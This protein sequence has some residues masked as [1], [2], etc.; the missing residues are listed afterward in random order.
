MNG[1]GSVAGPMDYGSG[2]IRPKHALDPGLV[3][4]ASYQDYL[5]FACASAGSQL[6]R[7]FPCPA[8]PPP[9]YQ[10]NHPSVAVHGFNGSVT[11]HRTVTNVG[12]GE[13]RYTVAVV[14]PAGVSVKVSPKRLSFARAGEKKAFRITMEA[15]KGSS[16]GRVARGQFVA[17]S[18]A[19][20][21]GAHVV[22]SPIVVLVA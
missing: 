22:R 17:G 18:Y 7:S 20:S 8:R 1:D 14:E 9:P 11:V 12:S 16:S 13:A 2:H 15:K 6:D 19:W 10:L 4:D 3:Y 5:L 21:D